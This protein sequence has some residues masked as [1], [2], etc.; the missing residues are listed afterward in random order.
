MHVYALE[1]LHVGNEGEDSQVPEDIRNFA[2]AILLWITRGITWPQRKDEPVR[3]AKQP[4]L[5]T[6]IGDDYKYTPSQ[7]LLN[8]LYLFH[9]ICKLFIS[10]LAFQSSFAIHC[11]Y[12]LSHALWYAHFIC[13]DVDSYRLSVSLST[14]L[15]RIV[16]YTGNCFN[17]QALCTARWA[18]AYIIYFSFKF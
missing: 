6:K 17:I 10:S 2:S 9:F 11:A 1:N 13:T 16:L 4:I 18:K 8:S 5:I 3:C 14:G 15:Y 12:T 7:F